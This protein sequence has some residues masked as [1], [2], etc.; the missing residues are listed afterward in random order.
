[1]CAGPS[2][3]N[4]PCDSP[5]VVLLVP[6]LPECRASFGVEPSSRP[7]RTSP[8][9]G[10]PP[11]S[12]TWGSARSSR[13]RRGLPSKF[14][15]RKLLVH[16]AQS[17]GFCRN[18]CRETNAAN[19]LRM[20]CIYRHAVRAV[21]SKISPYIVQM[22]EILKAPQALVIIQWPNNKHGLGLWLHLLQ[23]T[24]SQLDPMVRGMV[25]RDRN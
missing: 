16:V 9:G 20:S 14:A 25:H 3:D 1:M 10:C 24:L 22:R 6:A 12:G 11:V 15:R 18:N 7:R 21:S 4:Y 2:K 19:G 23:L 13:R 17:S 5:S 8:G